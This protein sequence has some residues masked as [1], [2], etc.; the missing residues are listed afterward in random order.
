MT[1]PIFS[2]FQP[3]QAMS[4]NYNGN[5]LMGMMNQIR[6]SPNPQQ[7]MQNMIMNNSN[8]RDIVNYINQNGGDARSAFYNLAAQKGIDPESILQ[9]LR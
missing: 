9:R 2:T 5:S 8:F 7:A 3:R 4:Q 6:Q 1:N